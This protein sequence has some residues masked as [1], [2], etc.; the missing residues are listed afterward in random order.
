MQIGPVA[1]QEVQILIL[2]V[3]VE[4]SKPI[5]LYKSNS[6]WFCI[7]GET[8]SVSMIYYGIRR[9]T[10]SFSCDLQS[11]QM[12]CTIYLGDRC[13]CRVQ[14]HVVHSYLKIEERKNLNEIE[15]N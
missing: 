1:N 3:T 12:K 7:N 14:L 8:F 15:S 6:I 11:K 4:R 9:C 10:C 5:E 2:H 13:N